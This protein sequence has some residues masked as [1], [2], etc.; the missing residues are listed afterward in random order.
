[1]ASR[2]SNLWTIINR[3]NERLLCEFLGG[4]GGML[5][6]KIL[7]IGSLKTP[8]SAL[9]GRN[10]WQNGTE[11]WWHF[12][13]YFYLKKWLSGNSTYTI[14]LHSAN[15]VLFRVPF[16]I[17]HKISLNISF[18]LFSW[19][20]TSLKLRCFSIKIGTFA[21]RLRSSRDSAFSVKLGLSRLNRDGWTLWASVRCDCVI[22]FCYPFVWWWV[23]SNRSS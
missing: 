8:F 15:S 13:S 17:Y 18:K 3:D 9:S 10:M 6:Q 11:I 2:V 4:C 5:P 20:M 21:S 23:S 1:M 12:S 7:K 22:Q 16:I 19:S 14:K